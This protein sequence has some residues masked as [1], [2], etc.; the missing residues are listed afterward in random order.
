MRPTRRRLLEL[1][2]SLVAIAAP[3]ASLQAQGTSWPNKPIRIIVPGGPGGVTDIRARW[4]G[5]RLSSVL[6]QPVV[7]E[8]RVMGDTMMIGTYRRGA[9]QVGDSE[10]DLAHLP[11]PPTPPTADPDSHFKS[12]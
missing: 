2:A 5:E 10:K 3:I 9:L 12:N 1:T 11:V 6:G 7:I 8:N 4:L